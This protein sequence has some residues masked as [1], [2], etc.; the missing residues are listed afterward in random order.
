METYFIIEDRGADIRYE[1]VR[2]SKKD[3]L[4]WLR[5][6]N[7]HLWKEIYPDCDIQVWCTRDANGKVVCNGDHQ[8][9]EYRMYC[10]F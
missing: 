5:Y 6:N 8:P 9:W 7:C 10:E 2:G 1:V 4:K 3:C